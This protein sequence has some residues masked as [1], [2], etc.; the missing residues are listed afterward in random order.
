MTISLE[1]TL[2][3][4]LGF[5][6]LDSTDL[7]AVRGKFTHSLADTLAD[8]YETDEADLLWYDRRTLAA[9]SEGIDLAGS[10]LD[11]FGQTLTFG[12]IKGIYIYNR[13]TTTGQNLTVGGGSN[14]FITWLGTS[15]DE[16]VIGPSGALLLWNPKD[17]YEVTAATGDILTIDS[18]AASITYD[19]IIVGTSQV[20]P[21]GSG[22]GSGSGA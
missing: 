17:G 16:V 12:E 21:S 4:A 19:I 11:V 22:S 6:Y 1:T 14:P 2:G 3:L 7:N 13:S 8:G 20:Y 9:T 15:G 18:G 10:L 5:N